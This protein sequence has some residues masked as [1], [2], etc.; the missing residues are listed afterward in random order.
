M[1]PIRIADSAVD[2]LERQ[3]LAELLEAFQRHDLAAALEELAKADSRQLIG[4]GPGWRLT[5][6]GGIVA[7]FHVFV[8][9]DLLGTKPDALVVYAVDVWLEDFPE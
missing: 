6:S 1:R 2:D 3:V 7:G 5:I 8:A 9:Q 4:H